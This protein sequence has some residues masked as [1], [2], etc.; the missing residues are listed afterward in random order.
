MPHR[1]LREKSERRKAFE[2]AREVL[3][4]AEEAG[5]AAAQEG[6]AKRQA[7]SDGRKT[8]R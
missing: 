3:R 6:L 4:E 1:P 7:Y 2:R 8:E 5:R